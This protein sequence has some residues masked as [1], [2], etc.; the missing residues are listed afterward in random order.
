MDVKGNYY[1]FST[2]FWIP[3]TWFWRGS[4]GLF[5]HSGVR[6]GHYRLAQQVAA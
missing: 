3:G 5:D 1:D 2:F 6:G 4:F